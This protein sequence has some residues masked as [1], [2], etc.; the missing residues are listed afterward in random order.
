MAKK[1]GEDTSSEETI[2]LSHYNALKQ[3][4]ESPRSR[5]HLT[6]L[7]SVAFEDAKVGYSIATNNFPFRYADFDHLERKNPAWAK[8]ELQLA[9]W[10]AYERYLVPFNRFQSELVKDRNSA[11]DKDIRRMKRQM[12]KANRTSWWNKL[13]RRRKS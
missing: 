3:Q 11:V 10:D 8:I 2:F 9:H 4:G 13:V 7:T 1:D 5:A 12:E 6:Q